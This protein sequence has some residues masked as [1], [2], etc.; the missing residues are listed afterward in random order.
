MSCFLIKSQVYPHI[1]PRFY[2]SPLFL[3]ICCEPLNHLTNDDYKLTPSTLLSYV[4]PDI[5][6]NIDVTQI[7]DDEW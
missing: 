7:Y 3:A 5:D 6:I 2:K 4:N 1:F